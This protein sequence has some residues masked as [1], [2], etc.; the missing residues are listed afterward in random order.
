MAFPAGLDAAGE[1]VVPAGVV[2][3]PRGFAFGSDGR[4]FL[5]SGVGPG[6][7]GDDTVVVFAPGGSVLAARFVMDP[8]LSP[9]DLA[10]AP[11][12][13]ILVSSEQP[14]GAPDAVT[15]IR[16]YDATD[17]HLIRVF[18]SNG[19]TEFHKPRG[20]RFGPNGLLYCVAQDEVVA[21]N[22]ETGECLGAVVRMPRLNGQALEFFG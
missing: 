4:L 3:F 11:N 20:L 14:F 8:G 9:L 5:A 21:F 17:G 22:F 18:S 10:I 6:G 16:E 1:L 7:E 19:L 13:N 12:E 2:P 15:T